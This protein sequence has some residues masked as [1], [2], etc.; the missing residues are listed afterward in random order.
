LLFLVRQVRKDFVIT[1][2]FR[3]DDARV[4]QPLYAGV[5]WVTC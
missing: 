3:V 2:I 1:G 4:D 5:P